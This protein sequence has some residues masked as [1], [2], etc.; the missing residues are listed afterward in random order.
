[1]LRGAS[2]S[3]CFAASTGCTNSRPFL[4]ICVLACRSEAAPRQASD[5]MGDH[6]R[7]T[8]TTTRTTMGHRATCPAERRRT[9]YVARGRHRLRQMAPVQGFA[10]LYVAFVIS[11]GAPISIGA[12][13]ADDQPMADDEWV[14]E[15]EICVGCGEMCFALYDALENNAYCKFCYDDLPPAWQRERKDKSPWGRRDTGKRVYLLDPNR[16]LSDPVPRR[17]EPSMVECE[18]ND[19]RRGTVI[20][21]LVFRWV[22]VGCPPPL[23]LSTA[24]S[25]P[26][27]PIGSSGTC[28]RISLFSLLVPSTRPCC[29]CSPSK[30]CWRSSS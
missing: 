14:V 21:C 22:L 8:T 27:C 6:P 5:G 15:K 3:D 2:N 9:P 16:K 10:P 12:P 25:P 7:T 20:S 24:R 28:S 26:Y 29:K 13:M 30:A 23:R 17:F 4:I 11:G 19:P 18:P 1:M